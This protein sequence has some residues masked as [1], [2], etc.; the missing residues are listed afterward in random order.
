M[1]WTGSW[2]VIKGCLDIA[3]NMTLF[4]RLL[5]SEPLQLRTS[6]VAACFYMQQVEGIKF[7]DIPGFNINEAT[8]L[9]KHLQI[10]FWITF[11]R[12]G[13][14]F[15]RMHLDELNLKIGGGF[16][17]KTLRRK[18]YILSITSTSQLLP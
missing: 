5:M 2:L 7:L 15:V 6:F 18:N 11:C 16:V 17:G 4:I 8:E 14:N 10:Q 9:K 12:C 1:V 3:E 13:E